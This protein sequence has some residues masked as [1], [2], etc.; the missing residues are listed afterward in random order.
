M[1]SLAL[2]LWLVNMA[3]DTFGH[4]SFKIA[5]SQGGALSTGAYWRQLLKRPWL[6][7]GISC[8][9]GE[10]FV[11]VAFLSQVPLGAGV[12]LGSFNIVLL[13]IAGRLLFK[14]MFTP[15]RILGITLITL[16]VI[17]VGISE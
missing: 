8:Y 9:V 17:L 14:E 11:W 15:W 1:T 13:M 4:L 3:M 6:W 2:L 10:F 16:G 12:M 5:A 7:A